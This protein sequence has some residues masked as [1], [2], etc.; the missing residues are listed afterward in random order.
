MQSPA[1]FFLGVS[2]ESASLLFTPQTGLPLE[3]E[4]PAEVMGNTVASSR[5][6]LSASRETAQGLPRVPG[7]DPEAGSGA[8][9]TR[10][11]PAEVKM[12]IPQV[13]KRTSQSSREQLST[14]GCT[15]LLPGAPSWPQCSQ[16]C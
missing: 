11:L 9:R 13:E 15:D 12:G 16:G 3:G 14:S 5:L 6:K 4:P 1:D 10:L 7:Q 2:S 8:E